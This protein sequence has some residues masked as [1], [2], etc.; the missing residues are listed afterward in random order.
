MLACTYPDFDV[1]IVDQSTSDATGSVVAPVAERDARLRYFHVDEVGL[2]RAYNTGV[3]L[4]ERRP[5]R[6][7]G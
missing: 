1:T 5:D 7:H 4:T 6:V 3:R 2:S